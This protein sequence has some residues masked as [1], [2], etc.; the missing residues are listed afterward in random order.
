MFGSL[1]EEL[2]KEPIIRFGRIW[3]VSCSYLASAGMNAPLL[4]H[5]RARCSNMNLPVEGCADASFG[6]LC[7]SVVSEVGSAAEFRYAFI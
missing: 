1:A 5:S 6:L 2:H 4:N 7:K 3:F